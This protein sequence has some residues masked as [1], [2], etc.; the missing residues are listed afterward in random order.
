MALDTK[1][2]QAVVVA[3]GDP[4]RL[5]GR[6]LHV[7]DLPFSGVSQDGILNGPRHLLDVPYQS[8]VVVSWGKKTLRGTCQTDRAGKCIDIKDGEHIFVCNEAP[9]NQKQA[10]SKFRLD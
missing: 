6:P 8:L 2:L 9:G 5:R 10:A 7:V 4:V 3:D 1:D